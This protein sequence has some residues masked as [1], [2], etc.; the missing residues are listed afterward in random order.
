MEITKE[1]VKFRK[2]LDDE[3]IEWK[4]ASSLD[5]YPMWRTHFDYRGYWWSVIHGYG[6]YGGFNSFEC[7]DKGLLEV[8]SEA[9]NGGEPVGWLTAE[10]VMAY[11]RG[12]DHGRSD[13]TE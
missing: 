5:M 9:I 13:K 6:S 12:D 7:I 11:V 4:D 8:M 3:G 10:Q 1:M 2:M